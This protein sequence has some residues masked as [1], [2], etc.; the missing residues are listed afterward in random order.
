MVVF[1]YLFVVARRA[2]DEELRE[3]ESGHEE[4]RIAFLSPAGHQMAES[5]FHPIPSRPSLCDS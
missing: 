1:V 5:P 3:E 2:V 4:E